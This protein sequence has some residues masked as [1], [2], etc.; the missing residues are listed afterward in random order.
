MLYF[1]G[2][3]FSLLLLIDDGYNLWGDV[4]AHLLGARCGQ[5]IRVTANNVVT[6]EIMA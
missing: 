3:G 4:F 6:L 1:L 2:G 5:M